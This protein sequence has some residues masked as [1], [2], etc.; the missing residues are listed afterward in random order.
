VVVFSTVQDHVIGSARAHVERL[1]LEA[2]IDKLAT[3]PEGPNKVAMQLV[4]DLFA[5]SAIEQDR[6]WFMEHGRFSNAKS[7]AVTA[8][9]NELCRRVRP[10]AGQLVDA[11]D[12]PPQM[13]RAEIIAPV[14]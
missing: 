3:M 8:M 10:I 2:F 6:A 5:L 1:L 9:V 7:K 13:L 11:F 14:A 12:I 4:C